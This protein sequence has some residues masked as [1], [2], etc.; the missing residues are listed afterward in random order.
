[1]QEYNRNASWI[2]VRWELL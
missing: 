2:P 1:M